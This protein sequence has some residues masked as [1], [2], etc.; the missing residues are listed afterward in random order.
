MTYRG[1]VYFVPVLFSLSTISGRETE[2]EETT[3]SDE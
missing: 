3:G 1:D 2:D